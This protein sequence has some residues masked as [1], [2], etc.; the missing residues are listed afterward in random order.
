[1]Y[2]SPAVQ[3]S[4]DEEEDRS[5]RDKMGTQHL[6]PYT[7][8]SPTQAH[9][10]PYSPTDGPHPRLSYSN[11]YH[12]QGSTATALPLPQRMN[13]SPRLGPLSPPTTHH[14]P[15]INGSAYT[16]RDT[17]ASTYYDP[18]SDQGSRNINWTRSAQPPHQSPLQVRWKATG[19]ALDI[20]L[21]YYAST[22]G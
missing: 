17:G 19:W 12:A 5:K 8:R 10:K 2:H 16:S 4:P 22:Q 20:V 21:W 6:P 3:R 15:P 11:Q 13:G 7:T 18:T 1:M 14:L 9:Y